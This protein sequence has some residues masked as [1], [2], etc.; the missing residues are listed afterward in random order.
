MV[1]GPCGMPGSNPGGSRARQVPALM[2]CHPEPAGTSAW[3]VP[4]M[5]MKPSDELGGGSSHLCLCFPVGSVS[6]MRVP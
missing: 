6:D 2:Y 3:G 4:R 1:L 5:E